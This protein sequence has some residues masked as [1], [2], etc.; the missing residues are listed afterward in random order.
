MRH[1]QLRACVVD[2]AGEHS[3]GEVSLM[4]VTTGQLFEY[5]K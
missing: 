2:A 4:E 3:S 5:S 1:L